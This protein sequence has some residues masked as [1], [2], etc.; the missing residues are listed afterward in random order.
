MSASYEG[1]FFFIH[2]SKPKTPYFTVFCRS[3]SSFIYH[4]RPCQRHYKLIKRKRTRFTKTDTRSNNGTAPTSDPDYEDIFCG[5]VVFPLSDD[6]NNNNL[7]D[8]HVNSQEG[9]AADGCQ[10]VMIL[11]FGWKKHLYITLI[12]CIKIHKYPTGAVYYAAI[13]HKNAKY[14]TGLYIML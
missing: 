3:P 2:A 11:I 7:A 1:G 6:D 9:K 5:G 10:P 4:L 13:M 8:E 12:L 14:S